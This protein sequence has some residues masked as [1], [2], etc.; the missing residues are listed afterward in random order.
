MPWNSSKSGINFQDKIFLDIRERIIQLLIYFCKLASRFSNNTDGNIYQYTSGEIPESLIDKTA[1]VKLY[2]LPAPIKKPTFEN[3]VRAKNAS[4]AEK[5][6]WVIGL[7]E[8]IILADDLFN[9][10]FSNKNRFA[11]IIID[12]TLEIAFKE[13]LVHVISKK[14]TPPIG[15]TALTNLLQNRT[16]MEGKVKS[17]LGAR[18]STADWNLLD[19]Y[20]KMRCDLIHLKSTF[21]PKDTDVLK[22]RSIVE[23]VLGI[24]FSLKF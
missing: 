16:L 19:H 6:T 22:H 11:T 20:Y 18:I 7:Y 13:Y 15:N 9:S 3:T 24:L 23:K 2:P 12:S 8:G 4:V 5:K 1:S 10:N 14:A 21:E 17:Y